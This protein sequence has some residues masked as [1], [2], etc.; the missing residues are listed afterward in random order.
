MGASYVPDIFVPSEKQ[1]LS[2]HRDFSLRPPQPAKCLCA[3]CVMFL[4][5]A[6]FGLCV[7][8][9]DVQAAFLGRKAAC[10]S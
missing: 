2:R 10:T 1:I 3:N 5:G 4:F 7:L 9:C 6:E 8:L